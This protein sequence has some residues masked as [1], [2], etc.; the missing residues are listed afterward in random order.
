MVF[1]MLCQK[2]QKKEATTHFQR[3]VNGQTTVYHVCEDC[4]KELGL[5]DVFHPFGF[6]MNNL[7]SSLFSSPAQ[8]PAGASPTCPKCGI[9][10]RE[11]MDTGK[12]GCDECYHTFYRELAPS[13]EKIHGKAVHTGKV[14]RSA[15]AALQRRRQVEQLKAQL[16]EAV[17]QENFEAAASLRDQIKSLESEAEKHD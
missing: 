3:T 1:C 2:C 14:P 15:G 10:L 7:F 9:T 4:A 11:I 8:T 16:E 12:M 17:K 6:P 5:T 13:I